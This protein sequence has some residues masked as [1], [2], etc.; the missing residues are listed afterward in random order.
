MVD[1]TAVA[2]AGDGPGENGSEAG[3]LP[4]ALGTPWLGCP[5]PCRQN[6]FHDAGKSG[7]K[8]GRT[9]FLTDPSS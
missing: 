8:Y 1:G 4:L 6:L 9:L 2:A 7:R 3:S 5:C